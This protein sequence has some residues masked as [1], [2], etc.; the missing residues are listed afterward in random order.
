MWFSLAERER[1]TSWAVPTSP[2]EFDEYL[3][4]DGQELEDLL[5]QMEID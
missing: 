4:R 2:E 5:S 3:D 1:L